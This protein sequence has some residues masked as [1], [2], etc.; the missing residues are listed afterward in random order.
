MQEIYQLSG[1]LGFVQFVEEA[2]IFRLGNVYK[3]WSQ[4]LG[5]KNFVLSFG[6]G[7]YGGGVMFI[8]D[9]L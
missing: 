4:C 5:E 2:F 3:R 7:C 8:C 1:F 9:R 6:F